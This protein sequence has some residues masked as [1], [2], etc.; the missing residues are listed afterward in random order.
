MTREARKGRER[1][2]R[3]VRGAHC[4]A[5]W[6]LAVAVAVGEVGGGPGSEL[7]VDEGLESASGEE[8]LV[9]GEAGGG[10]KGGRL[11]R[12]EAGLTF[13]VALREGRRGVDGGRWWA[14]RRGIGSGM[15]DRGGIVGVC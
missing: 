15:L 7:E 8:V 12:V 4:C 10:G 3:G 13:E 6:A 1:R 14:R 11:R 5:S 9:V 2:R